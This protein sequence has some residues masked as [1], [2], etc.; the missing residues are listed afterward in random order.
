MDDDF[1]ISDTMAAV[2]DFV[3]KIGVPLSRGQLNE[4]ERD[5]I[6]DV[7]KRL[8]AVLGVMSFEEETLS[9][10]AQRLLGDRKAARRAGDWKTSDEIRN[11]LLAMGIEVSDTASGVAWRLK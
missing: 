11:R 2:F 3:G 1:N 4:K 6:L 8:D 10:E 7:L 5:S 9:E